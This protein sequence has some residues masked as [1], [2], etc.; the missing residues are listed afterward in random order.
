MVRRFAHQGETVSLRLKFISL[1][2]DSW[3]EVM[4]YYDACQI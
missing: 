1:A 4:Q 2:F 3:L